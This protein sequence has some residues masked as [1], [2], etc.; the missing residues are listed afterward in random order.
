MMSNQT[1]VVEDKRRKR[2]LTPPGKPEPKDDDSFVTPR[3]GDITIQFDNMYGLYEI[4]MSGP[5]PKELSGFF[6]ERK[7][8]EKAVEQY[9]F[10]Y[11]K[12]R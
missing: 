6:T 11:W 4:S 8:A 5:K 12:N 2:V 9:L 10:N 1:M 7:R 3:G